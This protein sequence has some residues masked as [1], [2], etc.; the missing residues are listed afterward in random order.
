MARILAL[1]YG[2]KRTGMAVTDPL[3]MIASP[4]DTIPSHTLFDFLK[5]Y[6]EKEDVSEVVIGMPKNTD[7]SD[8]NATQIVQAAVNRFRKL[9]PNKKLFLHDERFTSKMALDA[10]I[11][12]GSKKKDRIKNKGNID[13]VS[14]AIILQSY[15]E[16]NS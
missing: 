9:F 2:A 14:A 13:K 3:G 7:G 6:F 4:L 8:T 15:L 5:D 16:A 10:M 12:G 11:A 1:D